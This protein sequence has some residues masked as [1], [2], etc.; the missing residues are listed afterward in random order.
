M[1]SAALIMAVAVA[2]VLV[3]VRLFRLMW[4]APRV[5]CWCGR[6]KAH[7]SMTYPSM[8]WMHFLEVPHSG[9]SSGRSIRF[10]H[11]LQ[12]VFP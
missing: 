3:V 2:V 10:R 1:L 8:Q 4:M 6:S 12:M 9:Q 5:C 7:S 11:A